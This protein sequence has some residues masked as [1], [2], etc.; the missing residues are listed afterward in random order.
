MVSEANLTNAY[1]FSPERL[2]DYRPVANG[3][4]SFCDSREHA[5]LRNIVWVDHAD[6]VIL[7]IASPFSVLE[8]LVRQ[9]ISHA[10]TEE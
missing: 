9:V 3:V 8:Q 5:T 7:S 2:P 4:F 10:R 6:D 1:D